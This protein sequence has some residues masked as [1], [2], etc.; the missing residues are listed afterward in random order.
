MNTAEC[1]SFAIVFCFHFRFIGHTNHSD[2]RYS[3]FSDSTYICTGRVSLQKSSITGSYSPL[4]TLHGL[5]WLST[6]FLSLPSVMSVFKKITFYKI[7]TFRNYYCWWICGL[8]SLNYC[9]PI[10][11][12][13]NGRVL[14]RISRI[15]AHA[16]SARSWFYCSLFRHDH[17]MNCR[18]NLY[19][20]R[21]GCHGFHGTR[22][23]VHKATQIS[24]WYIYI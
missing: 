20:M 15:L 4:V 21:S 5:R 17:K 18:F 3:A 14:S 22:Y 12:L 13:I 19:Y 9:A 11:V 24:C 6:T 7:V 10:L 8:F 16:W 1:S 23:C 2:F